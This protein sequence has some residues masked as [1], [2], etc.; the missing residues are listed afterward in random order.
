MHIPFGLAS[1]FVD[2]RE[3]RAVNFS[4]DGFRLRFANKPVEMSQIYLHFFDLEKF[5]YYKIDLKE[6]HMEKMAA[7]SE[8]YYEYKIQ[9]EDSDYK[10]AFWKLLLQYDRYVRLKLEEDDRVL[11]EQMTGCPLGSDEIRAQSFGEQK[12]IWF[13]ENK[14][15]QPLPKAVRKKREYALSLDREL[16]YRCYLDHSLADFIRIYEQCN[17]S[18]FSTWLSEWRGTIPDRLYIGNQFCHLL[19]PKD[20]LL[21]DMLEMAWE[22][23]LAVTLAF[24][25]IRDNLLCQ[26]KELLLRLERWCEIRRTTLEV[27]INDWG[28]AAIV[29]EQCPNLIPCLG[30]LLNKRKK[31][32]RM[33]WKQGDTD[34]FAENNLNSDFYREFLQKEYGI[35]R[36]EW[37]SCGYGITFPQ[38]RNS[39]H[40]PFYQTNTSQYCPTYAVC[41]YGERGKQTLPKHCLGYCQE[42]SFLYP[43]AMYMTGRYNS[44]FGLDIRLLENPD[45]Q[46]SDCADRIVLGLL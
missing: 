27:V 5:C 6:F 22:Q 13:M 46:I 38:G 21:F 32:P 44:L 33:N 23:H 41:V 12:K 14:K 15:L 9:T 8:F 25:Y 37:E 19:F 39:L 20:P 16:W 42:H 35:Q 43:E 11:A 2:G 30:I 34:L 26:T 18:V 3:I 28:M 45:T 29:K 40:I 4:E 17:E 24:S 7:Q 10:T 31:D 1:V 36:Y